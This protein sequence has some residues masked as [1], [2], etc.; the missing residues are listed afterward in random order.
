VVVCGSG[1]RSSIGGSLLQRA[2][3][4]RVANGVGGV[5]AWRAAGRPLEAG[6]APGV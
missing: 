1:Y 5:D 2:G 6:V 4:A 3:F